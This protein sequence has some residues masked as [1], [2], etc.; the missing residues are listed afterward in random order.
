MARSCGKKNQSGVS[1]V[2]L[3]A[4]VAILG[5]TL[6][7]VGTSFRLVRDAQKQWQILLVHREAQRT[8][9]GM[10]REVRNSQYLISVSSNTL[11]LRSFDL[12]KLGYDTAVPWNLSFY[13][14]VNIGTITYQYDVNHPQQITRT[15]TFPGRTHTTTLLQNMLMAPTPAYPNY[16]FFQPFPDTTDAHPLGVHIQLYM[17]NGWL[18]TAPHF[19]ESYVMSR[20]EPQAN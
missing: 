3:M 17:G 12:A 7:L 11:S 15:E 18:S 19:Y 10:M 4:S 5:A 6:V 8:L 13:N 14:S 16:V 2:E 1:L 20:S 9:Y